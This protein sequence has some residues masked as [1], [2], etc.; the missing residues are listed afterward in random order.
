MFAKILKND[1]LANLAFFLV[2]VIGL[3]SYMAMPRQQD[4]EINFNWIQV[5]TT[6]PGA[7][8][9]DVERRITSPIED[10]IQNIT[11]IRF[12]TSQSRDNLSTILI[13]FNDLPTREFDKRMADLRREI[14]NKEPELPDAAEKPFIFEITTS[15]GFPTA[16]VLVTGPALDENLRRYA[17]RINKELTSFRE[18]DRVTDF[19]FMEPE[20]HVNFIPDKLTAL[21]I[22]PTELANNIASTFI[23]SSAG[24]ITIVNQNWL[25]RLQGV[26]NDPVKLGNTRIKTPAGEVPLNTIANVERGREQP[27]ELVTYGGQPAVM[28]SVAKS[29]NINTLKMVERIKTY[30]DERNQYADQIGARLVLVDDQTELTRSALNIMQ[31]NAL[32]GL[33]MVLVVTFIFLGLKMSLLT[34]IA[35]PFILAGVFWVLNS[36]GETLNV[37]VLLGVIISLGMLVDDAVVVVESIY[38]RLE[39]GVDNVTAAIEGL[40]EVIAP[41]TASVF[42]TI[43][44]FL[45]LMLLPGILGQFLKVV[46]IVVTLA[47]L[48]S[49]IEAYW[50]LPAHI[51]GF[52]VKLDNKDGFQKRRQLFLRKL[53]HRYSQLLIRALRHPLRVLGLG[54]GALTLAVVFMVGGFVKVN[55]FA[56][57]TLRLFY[58]NLEMPAGTPL[59]KTLVL[60]ERIESIVREKTAPNEVRSVV[61]TAGQQL[62]ETSPLAGSVFGQVTVSLLP[63]Q[64]GMA[65][66]DE[67]IEN[68]EKEV[69]AIVGPVNVSF[70][71]LS[72]GPPT[73]SPIELKVQGNDLGDIRAAVKDLM[74]S[75]GG[76]EGVRDIKS[77]DSIGQKVLLLELNQ[78]AILQSGLNSNDVRRTI[79]LLVD[80]EI[81]S[82]FQD[83]GEEVRLR[84]KA[85]LRETISID[86]IIAH[87]MVTPSGAEIPLRALVK[88]SYVD[89]PI[90]IIHYNFLRTITI[91]ADINPELINTQQANSEVLALWKKLEKN[92]PNLQIDQSGL[93]DDINESLNNILILFVFGLLL[94]YLIIATQF[95]SY[96]QPLIILFTVFLAFIGVIY[97]LTVSR[98]PFSLYTMYGAVALAGISVNAAI[99]LVSAAN[100]RRNKGMSPL[101]AIIY[102]GRR[103][104]VP[105]LITSFTTIAGLASL[106]LGLGGKSALW[107]P[108]ATVIVWGLAFSTSLTLF[109]IPGLYLGLERIK[110][111]RFS[112]RSTT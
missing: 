21:G 28:L 106:A 2:I 77:D 5:V 89:G 70:L 62:T 55:F 56:S 51:I 83:K 13:R 101:H 19:G 84:I 25:V 8:A 46:P 7:S 75:M 26:Y 81:V 110:R 86:E 109:V 58:I 90:Q 59:E 93:L 102:A 71:R 79:S 74:A 96:F 69:N 41:V 50:M 48:I 68:I 23:D 45:P 94:M 33:F 10:A 1:V 29:P 52:N 57:D 100:D 47:L 66:V 24:D 92:Y 54:I 36:Q 20:L 42:T 95:R 39:R 108:I 37:M 72:G 34:S 53:R 44:A 65:S 105:I 30:I 11:D 85:D 80:G 107:G 18:V 67:V 82:A 4:P 76:I 88:A 31:S 103:R 78:D 73:T 87:Y 64:K 17:K 61:S 35:I 91:F 49:L 63:Q 27:S 40:K 22:N 111:Y 6:M 99:V 112:R 60:T 14:Q 16:T 3:L 43:A 12:V 32:L 97:G 38:Y 98:I 15:N 104:V 9:E